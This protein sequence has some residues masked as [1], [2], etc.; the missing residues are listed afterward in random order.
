MIL[1]IRFQ[2]TSSRRLNPDQYIYLG[3]FSSRRLGKTSSTSFQG[4]FFAK[5]SSR[6][7]QYRFRRRLQDVFKTS[8]RR[9]GDAFKT[10]FQKRLRDIFKTS[11]RRLQD[12]FKTFGQIVLQSHLQDT[13]KTSSKCIIKLNCLPSSSICQGHTS[14]KFMVSVENLQVWWK[15]LKFNF[16]PLLYLLMDAYRD[17][18]RNWW[19]NYKGAYFAKIPSDFKL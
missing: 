5:T 18:F 11:L 10:L 17:V 7:L 14:E 2:T 15:C 12:I 8:W 3:H 1:V 6:H 16:F 19:G 13:F 9:L 4:V